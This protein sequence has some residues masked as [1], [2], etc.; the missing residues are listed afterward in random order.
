MRYDGT[1]KLLALNDGNNN[2]RCGKIVE[3]SA[4]LLRDF[5]HIGKSADRKERNGGE[6]MIAIGS[7]GEGKGEVRRTEPNRERKKPNVHKT[8]YA[9]H[10]ISFL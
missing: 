8:I 3:K 9:Y 6:K 10:S 1:I 4:T 2:D 5:E 7:G